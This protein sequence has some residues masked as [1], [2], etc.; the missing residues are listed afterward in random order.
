MSD[1]SIWLGP[2][3]SLLGVIMGFIATALFN[4]AQHK[5]QIAL[6]KNQFD[7]QLEE[8]R[9]KNKMELN[10]RLLD[11]S[12]AIKQQD[13]SDSINLQETY[14]FLRLEFVYLTALTR[15]A[16]KSLAEKGTYP[17]IQTNIESLIT[18]PANIQSNVL[19]DI[20]D[21]RV[22]IELL[23]N[24]QLTAEETKETLNKL[25]HRLK[26]GNND[27]FDAAANALKITAQF[28]QEY[29]DRMCLVQ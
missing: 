27:C 23:N 21:A 9:E 22:Y 3:L 20:L 13:I 18:N 12:L 1:V 4:N 10:Y 2:T 29:Y 19:T 8:I 17:K 7:L 24:G 15:E 25:L 6:Q 16:I 14:T 11:H 26:D 5:K 28:K